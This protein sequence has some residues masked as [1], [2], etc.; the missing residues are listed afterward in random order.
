MSRR[1]ERVGEQ[2]R[3]EISGILRREVT[4]PRIGL[5]TIVRV[6]VSPDLRNALVFWSCIDTGGGVDRDT[7]A[8]G[9]HSAA[10]FVRRC[11]AQRLSLKRMPALDFRYDGSLEAGDRVLAVIRELGDEPTH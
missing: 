1:L 3:E 8:S 9:L 2:L 5:V 4:D 6:D 10:P 11:L 7:V